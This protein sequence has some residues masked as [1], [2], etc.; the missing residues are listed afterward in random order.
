MFTNQN[1]G[2]SSELQLLSEITKVV[3]P[4]S[5]LEETMRGIFQLS[6]I[7]IG[8]KNLIL[9]TINYKDSIF[10]EIFNATNVS[11]SNI[12]NL[13]NKDEIIYEDILSDKNIFILLKDEFKSLDNVITEEL[14]LDAADSVF[15]IPLI[16]LG[17]LIGITIFYKPSNL[18]DLTSYETSTIFHAATNTIKNVLL[19]EKIKHKDQATINLLSATKDIAKIIETQHEP[20]YVIPLMGEIMDKYIAD[21]LI[22]IFTKGNDNVFK[23]SWPASYS[24][25]RLDPLLKLML[26]SKSPAEFEDQTAIAIPIFTKSIIT[27]AIIADAKFNNLSNNDKHL[28]RDLSKQCSITISRANMYSETVKQATV[29]ALT[30]LDNRRQLDKRLLQEASLVL[31]TKRPLSILM[32]DIDFFKSIN[33]THGHSVGDH[34]LREVGSIIKKATREYDIAGR[35]GGEEF[36]IILPDTPLLGAKCLAERLRSNVENATIN[37]A[38]FVGSKT[39]SIKL[40]VSIG[41][42]EFTTIA[43]NPA[44]IYE[45]ADI[46]LYKAKQDGRNRVVLFNVENQ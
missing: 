11:D 20:S 1:D 12:I 3:D 39:E 6:E 41:I 22:Y 19:T 8:L 34:V 23:L 31:R 45:E 42:A 26:E 29:D 4:T 14:N 9:Y 10:E 44:D 25:N 32:I 16:K 28:L 2:F 15:L 18:K 21:P 46:A 43:K 5:S 17:N 27:G 7:Y 13:F 40:T 38:N 24:K 35:Y 37:I 33:D 30:N 36:V